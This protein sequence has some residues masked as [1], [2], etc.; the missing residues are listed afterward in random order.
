MIK[1]LAGKGLRT[2]KHPNSENKQ[3][4]KNLSINITK[5]PLGC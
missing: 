4:N 3:R 1:H 2:E 5:L